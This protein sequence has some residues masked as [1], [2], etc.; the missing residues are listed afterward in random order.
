M[1]PS[2]VEVNYRIK[3]S[4]YDFLTR[5]WQTECEALLNVQKNISSGINECKVRRL[6]SI[7]QTS[8]ISRRRCNL[9]KF[10][11]KH[12]FPLRWMNAD[13]KNANDSLPPTKPTSSGMPKIDPL[14]TVLS[15]DRLFDATKCKSSFRPR[16]RNRQTRPQ[17]HPARGPVC[18]REIFPFTTDAQAPT[19]KILEIPYEAQSEK[20]LFKSL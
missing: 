20:C 9:N 10:S 6:R 4:F 17:S 8:I 7:N 2:G 14:L 18:C 3:R 12:A 15:H 1:I 5:F 16:R 19:Q 11:Y 13:M